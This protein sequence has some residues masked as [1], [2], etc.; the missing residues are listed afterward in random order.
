MSDATAL[1]AMGALNLVA[2]GFF[3][4]V[5][6]RKGSRGA[7]EANSPRRQETS[8]MGPEL[9]SLLRSMDE[10]ER[11]WNA[12]DDRPRGESRLAGDI[13]RWRSRRGATGAEPPPDP[14]EVGRP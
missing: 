11:D 9:A 6:L 12:G 5:R 2:F 14:A 13:L 4:A 7:H 10:V 8:E 3:L 1:I